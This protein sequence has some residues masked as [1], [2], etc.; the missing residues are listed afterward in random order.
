MKTLIFTTLLLGA[1]A[2][3]LMSQLAILGWLH[4]GPNFKSCVET[5]RYGEGRLEALLF[6]AIGLVSLVVAVAYLVR[7]RRRQ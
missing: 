1:A 7:E 6:P 2:W 3:F 5:N 4:G